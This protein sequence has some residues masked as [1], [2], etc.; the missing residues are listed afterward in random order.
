M[1]D[2]SKGYLIAKFLLKT[3]NMLVKTISG[4]KEDTNEQ[5]NSIYDL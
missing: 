5:I 2:S 1:H 4:F 3:K